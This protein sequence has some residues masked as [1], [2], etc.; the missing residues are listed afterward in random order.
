M[1]QPI[2]V[3]AQ[4]T[5]VPQHTAIQMTETISTPPSSETSE[6]KSSTPA[7]K[8]CSNCGA[9]R[10]PGAKFCGNCGSQ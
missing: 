8:F 3:V 9:A 2:P 6:E 1:Q 5:P 4:G 7:K 10:V